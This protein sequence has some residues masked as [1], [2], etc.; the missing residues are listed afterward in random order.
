MQPAVSLALHDGTRLERFHS[1]HSLEGDTMD[2]DEGR[3]SPPLGMSWL[4]Y[5]SKILS[6]SLCMSSI[7][8]PYNAM[9]G[10]CRSV[11]HGP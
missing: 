1:G 9:K 3:L 4:E 8:L 10:R 5:L 7:F 6:D 2:C 11:F